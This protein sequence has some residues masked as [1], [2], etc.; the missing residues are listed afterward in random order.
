MS[1]FGSGSTTTA[2]AS[3]TL[4]AFE[5]TNGVKAGTDG[6]VP[7]PSV[8]QESYLL[9]ANGDWTLN[10]KGGI[11]LAE[12]SDRIAT[13]EFVQDVVGNAVLA[14]N[15]QL[16]ALAD[17]T[18][19]GLADDQFLQYDLATGKWKNATLNLSLISDVNLAGLADGN[20]IVWDNN[21][22]EWVP[23]EGGGGGA[24]NLTD[25]GDVT[26]AGG[27]EFHFLVRNGAGQYVNQ[28]VSSADLSN[29]AD[30]ILRDGTV[31][32]TGHVSLGDFNL[33]N[34]G[35]VALDTISADGTTV[36]VSMTDNTA[37]AFSIKEGNNSYLTFNTTD[38]IE[39]IVFN[40][41][42]AF[43]FKVDFHND[44]V[45]NE[46]GN[47]ID[48]RV[49]TGTK[50]HA[51]FSDGGT[52]RVGIFQNAPTVPL[53]VVG[54]TKITGAL[55]LTGNITASNLGTASANATGDFLASNSS[56]DD[57]NDVALGGAL[58][59]GKILKVV[60]GEITQADETDTN[61][62]LTDE[63]VQDLV[64]GMV[65]GNTETDIT[66]SYD[67]AG[68][69]LNFVVDNTVARLSDP[70]LT[71]T[72]TAPTAIQGVN[73]TQIATTAY[74]QTEVTTLSLGTASQ[75]NV[76]VAN[77]D[78]VEL[79]A[80][81]L[82]AVSG[83]DLT[84]LGSIN[85]LSDVDT[86]NKAEGKVL[87][88]NGALNL[89]VG[90]DT[91]TQLTDEE[92]QDL[93]GTM[94]TAN[95]A[96]NTH[97]TFAYDDTEGANDGT[98]TAT[99]SL[100]ST[101]LT[102]TGNISL[103]GGDQ[104]LSGDK[105]FTGAVD[106]TV[107]T[108]TATTQGASN[109][110]TKV[111][112]TAYVDAQI[113]ADL[114]TLNLGGTYQGLDA[115][116]TALAGVATGANKLIYATGADAFSTTS[117]SAFGRSIIDDADAGAVR[118]TLGLGTAS[119]SNTGDFLAS[120]AGLNDLNN[121]TI[122]GGADKHFLV[123][124]G[125]GQYVNRLISSADLSNVAD[126]AFLASP[127]LTGN[128]TAPTQAQGNNSTSIATTAYV[129]TEIG[130][131]SVGGLSDVDLT[132]LNDTDGHV[133]AWSA[134]NDQFEAVANIADYTDEQARDTVGTA[135]A[136]GTHTG[137]TFLN[138]DAE[139]TIE[140]TVSLTSFSVGALS[141]VTLDGD[142]TTKHLLVHNGAGQFVNQRIDSEDLSDTANIALLDG[143][144]T[145][146]D[147]VEATTQAKA[148][149]TTLVATTA[150]VQL[151]LADTALT[152]TPTAP[153]AV[154]N[155]DTTQIAT[156]AFVTQEIGNT[157][158]KE[159]SDISTTDP[160]NGQVLKYTTDAGDDQNKY[161]PTTLGTASTVDTGTSNGEIPVLTTH[162]LSALS[163]NETADLII[164]GRYIETIDY[165]LVSDAFNVNNDFALDFNGDGLNDTF[166]NLVVI[167][168]E[169]DY[170]VLVC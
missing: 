153:P 98:I 56:I 16:S 145:F 68:G 124:N 11:A 161:V 109:N 36:S 65:S 2:G 91:N 21:A 52:D 160:T 125:A 41:P 86:T 85:I 50:T 152:G 75:K 32:F 111:A 83:A 144:Q 102:N 112:T 43:N 148:N 74:V 122:A 82:P 60:A 119:T 4:T 94:F 93:V 26:I 114:V 78:V 150:F 139:D 69:K 28:L 101:D 138:N 92:V 135:L 64:G 77:G 35:D 15:A 30:I 154:T 133:L 70:D 147:G 142:E 97:L 37:S 127:A 121:V 88:F 80:N 45:I 40:K 118:T 143:A 136:G 123:E 130:S 104:T 31:T 1:S 61:T 12:S 149:D 18:I 146:A 84:S 162:Y 168:A 106:L 7:G 155:T 79:G 81:G 5:G 23:G 53:D 100:A 89:V 107:A 96:G 76:G 113:D 117:I 29:N 87:R 151:Q 157:E 55:E 164:K 22:G 39:N 71:G 99:V 129:E 90:D 141:N 167:Y 44:V 163:A 14:G 105:V 19:A 24:T 62:Q 17:V 170:G 110:S 126:I 49:E 42:S 46:A 131:T 66:V 67:D 73:T 166:L 54:D 25:L 51:I 115:T 57:L 38:N 169:E 108:A 95:N 72:P 58:V 33:T 132:N 47:G 134:V 128:P 159:I 137:I 103:L 120:N 59:N 158:A 156:T 48:F 6:L 3:I 34:V 10:I 27:A 20:T 13:T 8:A 116:L 63:Q 165:G 9:G 140:A